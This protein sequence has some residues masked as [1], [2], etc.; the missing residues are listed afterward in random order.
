MRGT[1]RRPA[2]ACPPTAESFSDLIAADRIAVVE[3]TPSIISGWPPASELVKLEI[4]RWP[5]T[6]LIPKICHLRPSP[7]KVDSSC[8]SRP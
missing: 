8:A 3:A 2:A 5:A 6:L 1:P 7:L 4:A